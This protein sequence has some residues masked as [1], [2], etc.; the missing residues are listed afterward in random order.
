VRSGQGKEGEV[1][2]SECVMRAEEEENDGGR[3]HARVWK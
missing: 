1:L 2:S 3:E